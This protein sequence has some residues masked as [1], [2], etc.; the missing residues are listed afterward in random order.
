MAEPSLALQL[1]E[2]GE[3]L[4][5]AFARGDA[6]F[7]A[8]GDR[9]S[10]A[11]GIFARLGELFATLEASLAD[12]QL[13]HA[14]AA[15]S[16]VGSDIAGLAA[17]LLEEEGMLGRLR[18]L[19]AQ[20]ARHIEVIRRTI[21]A[22]NMLAVN[23]HISASDM[24]AE[25]EDVAS[26]ALRFKQLAGSARTTIAA[27]A[28][29]CDRLG[30][31]LD[32]A[33][34][35]QASFMLEHDRVLALLAGQIEDCVRAMDERRAKAAEV[36]RVIAVGSQRISADVGTV[37]M[38]LQVSDITRQRLDHVAQALAAVAAEP[39]S[40]GA[41]AQEPAWC[42]GLGMSEREA[43][44]IEVCGLE[45]AQMGEAVR[46][47]D[48]EVERATGSLRRLVREAEDLVAL[49]GRGYGNGQQGFASFLSVLQAEL[50]Q[51]LSLFGTC[52]RHRAEV[53][54]GMA[55][56][57]VALHKLLEQLA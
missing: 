24:A 37:V 8:I 20:L 50:D 32:A 12:P 47:F 31:A 17:A 35:R 39:A 2:I 14:A 44:A 40:D 10:E 19:N 54:A 43:I 30:K 16:G 48:D 22:I 25:G 46:D 56:A 55:A 27:A 13:G 36:S 18:E 3:A 26:F 38:A 4:P 33:Q 28:A 51:A 29:Q 23:A 9:L 53:D 52:Q 57:A 7:L 34:V 15:L 41:E 42:A 1:R 49:G 5:A 45:Q 6:A 21:R 11:V